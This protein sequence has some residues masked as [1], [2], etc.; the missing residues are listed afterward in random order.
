MSVLTVST[1]GLMRRIRDG[2]G[3]APL[4]LSR[5]L[6]QAAR[7][8]AFTVPLT[9]M[10]SQRSG[11][12]K[13]FRKGVCMFPKLLSQSIGDLDVYHPSVVTD[14]FDDPPKHHYGLI[15]A[16]P[17][18]RF[19]TWDHAVTVS[20]RG[21]RE[22]Y[23]TLSIEEIAAYPVGSIAADDCLLIL[24]FLPPLLPTTLDL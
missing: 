10:R 17:P 11:A 23:K 4:S 2:W 7:P 9:L 14:R 18:W 15:Y 22:H 19:A 8:R 20:A 6:C 16:D 5:D 1:N 12:P 13:A 3:L 24:W 21:R